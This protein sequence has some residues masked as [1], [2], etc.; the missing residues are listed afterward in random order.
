MTTTTKT[1]TTSVQTFEFEQSNFPSLLLYEFENTWNNITLDALSPDEQE[2]LSRLIG[3]SGIESSPVY[4]PEVLLVKAERGIVKGVYGPG[5]F[6]YGDYIVLKVGENVVRA[7]QDGDRLHVGKL[8]GKIT[9]IEKEDA[10][11]QKYP[12]AFCTF[13][14]PDKSVFKVRVSL[15]S[16]QQ[17]FSAGE[18]DATLVNE[19]S[20]LPYLAQVPA[21]AI[22]MSQ[23]GVGEF[24]I[25][26]FSKYQSENGT[27]HKIHLA[28]G[29]V[30]WARGNSEMLLDSDYT[31]P[32]GKPLTLVVSHIEEF[33]PDK[34]KVDNAIRERLPR[35]EGI[36]NTETTIVV[37]AESV[38]DDETDEHNLCVEE[39]QDPDKIP[40]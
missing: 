29:K 35:L 33:A 14:A 26:G 22:S 7:S 1:Q 12:T 4:R 40:F 34:F 23:L 39:R 31:K 5:L 37:D 15:D 9:V 10:K 19:E 11:K 36:V 21:P 20:I 17:G 18:L 16:Q 38:V 28:D 25:I 24:E 3:A 30:V 27:R 13:V 2:G 6:R 32:E 8:K